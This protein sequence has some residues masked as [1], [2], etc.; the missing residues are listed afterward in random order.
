[1][2]LSWPVRKAYRFL[3]RN[4]IDYSGVHA[5]KDQ[6]NLHYWNAVENLG[7]T[8]APVIFHWMLQQ[9]GLTNTL[10]KKK[11]VHLL[12]IGSILADDV[13]DATVWGSGIH[14]IDAAYQLRAVRRLRKLDIRAVRGP[15]TRALLLENGYNCPA[16]YGDPGILLPKIYHPERSVES[17]Y[18]VGLIRHFR[19][20]GDFTDPG[21]HKIDIVTED[22]QAFVNELFLCKKII[23]SSL[24]GIILAEAYGIP[25]VFLWEGLDDELMK[26]YD[27]Y[28]ST[29]RF[30]V[31]I[32]R[33]LPE[34]LSMEPMPLPS[35]VSMQRELMACF[36][37]DLWKLPSNDTM[38][39]SLKG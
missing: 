36:P 20:A 30:S 11:Y 22:Y 5:A 8:L 38:S 13:F 34:A 21:V 26:F 7:D 9:N 12:T 33:S 10:P 35:L 28:F 37:T 2:Y 19:Q 39:A 18:E 17:Q 15:I 24:H 3:T 6:V 25:T 29:D 14:K 1:M 4:A 16:V 23:S 27:W 32:A 31:Q